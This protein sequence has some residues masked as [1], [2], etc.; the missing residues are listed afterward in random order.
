MDTACV[1]THAAVAYMRGR[2]ALIDAAAAGVPLY[3]VKY[4]LKYQ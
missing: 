3:Q 1:H 2:A 4:Q